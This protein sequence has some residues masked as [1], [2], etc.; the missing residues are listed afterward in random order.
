MRECRYGVSVMEKYR[1][2]A[3]YL[4]VDV[5]KISEQLLSKKDGCLQTDATVLR[6][7]PPSQETPTTGSCHVNECEVQII[8]SNSVDPQT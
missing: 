1:R 6:E 2:D 7:A 4:Y 3:W 5:V 8:C